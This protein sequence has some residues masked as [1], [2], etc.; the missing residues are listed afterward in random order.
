MTDLLI[1]YATCA[2]AEDAG[3]IGRALVEERI[4]A[5]VTYYPH[6]AVYRWDEAVR[7]EAEY[8]L[9]AKTMPGEWTRLQA[10]ITELLGYEVPCVVAFRPEA[11]FPPFAEW[12]AAEL[13]AHADHPGTTIT[14]PGNVA[15][16]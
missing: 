16:V 10:R 6:R 15:S 7:D 12:V 13:G 11:A 9:L 1:V 14:G 2:S 4:A 8:T 5:C 3:R